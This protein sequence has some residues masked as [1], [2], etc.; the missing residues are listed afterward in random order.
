[1]GRL[2]DE[3]AERLK[4]M[5]R[6]KGASPEDAEDI[7]EEAFMA[8]LRQIEAGPDGW[9]KFCNPNYLFRI[10][11]NLLSRTRR[12]QVVTI[13]IDPRYPSPE[14]GLNLDDRLALQETLGRLS[15]QQR[16]VL[17]L[18]WLK[19]FKYKEAGEIMGLAE[20]TVANLLQQARKELRRWF[21]RTE[22]TRV[23]QA[24]K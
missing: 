12:K 4:A 1:M 9:E 5:L 24:E 16:E 22:G 23:D 14:D 8:L 11:S 7:C 2:Y 17:D 19:G 15:D 3:W 13:G 21:D 6:R 20:S 10:A 18:V